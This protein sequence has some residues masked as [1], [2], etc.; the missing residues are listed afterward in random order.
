MKI[1]TYK[2]VEKISNLT[3]TSV[4]M[5][6]A[7]T[8]GEGNQGPRPLNIFWMMNNFVITNVDLVDILG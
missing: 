4:S 2:K 6:K 7:A 8:G 3:R 5:P 1:K